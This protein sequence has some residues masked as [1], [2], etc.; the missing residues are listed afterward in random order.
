VG[1]FVEKLFYSWR[2]AVAVQMRLPAFDGHLPFI[3][4]IIDT[5]PGN[6]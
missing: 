1:E 6:L 3:D 2:S 4:D 5:H